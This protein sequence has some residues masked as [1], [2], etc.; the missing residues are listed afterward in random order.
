MET[1][2]RLSRR[3]ASHIC[4]IPEKMPSLNEYVNACRTNRYKAAALKKDLEAA[5]MPYISRLPRFDC[6][7]S[8]HFEWIES[9]RRRDYD[10]VAFA[11]KFILD[12]L[13]K[14]GKLKDDNRRFVVG[15]SDTF[16]LGDSAGCIITIQEERA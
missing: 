12:A 16:A 2:Q 1:E 3:L 8:I 5:I 14:A 11:K 7:V 9:N 15:F 10:N 6:P 4:E 13:V